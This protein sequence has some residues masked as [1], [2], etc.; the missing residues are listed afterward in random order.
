MT[1]ED[2]R[3]WMQAVQFAYVEECHFWFHLPV[4][5]IAPADLELME[6]WRDW[7]QELQDRYL[8]LHHYELFSPSIE[9]L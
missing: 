7:L 9:V 1:I 6:E 3:R 4:G 5:E 8:M 2:L